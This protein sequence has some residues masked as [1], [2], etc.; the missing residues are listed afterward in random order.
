VVP[1]GAQ[2][3]GG[4]ACKAAFLCLLT[5]CTDTI[6]RLRRA[7]HLLATRIRQRIAWGQLSYVRE[8]TLKHGGY[9]CNVGTW[10]HSS[11]H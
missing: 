8:E 5:S 2:D 9:S 6:I 4:Q 1:T 7:P 11:G 3:V 10:Q